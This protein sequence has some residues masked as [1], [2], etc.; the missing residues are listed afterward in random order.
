LYV[1]LLFLVVEFLL[2]LLQ[3]LRILTSTFSPSFFPNENCY[4][5]FCFES[6]IKGCL[7]LCEQHAKYFDSLYSIS[8]IPY[9]GI[10]IREQIRN[11]ATSD[12]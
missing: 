2:V 1:L 9:F 11:F 10:I 5:Y 3:I 4:H 12:Q 7:Y 8:P 6:S